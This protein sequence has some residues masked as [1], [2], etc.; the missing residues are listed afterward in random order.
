MEHKSSFQATSQ[1][2]DKSTLSPGC[3]TTVPVA[4]FERHA[5]RYAIPQPQKAFSNRNTSLWNALILRF[6]LTV[7][8]S[9]LFPFALSQNPRT[10][11]A[12]RCS[13]MRPYIY[14]RGRIETSASRTSIPRRV[15]HDRKRI[16]E[17]EK[18]KR[19][20]KSRTDNG[21]NVSLHRLPRPRPPAP[22]SPRFLQDYGH[23]YDVNL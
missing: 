1:L 22:F 13:T 10:N 19:T 16:K 7:V 9:S 8:Q 6:S 12:P 14:D 20:R 11:L 18:G 4:R 5:S 2:K 3:V 21:P 17:E 15:G 23:L